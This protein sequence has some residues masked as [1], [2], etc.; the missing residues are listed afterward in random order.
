MTVN[1]IEIKKKICLIG[2][3]GVGKT[4]LIRRFV[5]DQFSDDYIATFGTKIT[6]TRIKFPKDEDNIIDLYLMIWDVFGQK[7]FKKSQMKSYT[8]AKGAIIVCDITN[9]VS[10]FNAKTWSKILFSSTGR[11]PII[12][13]ANKIDLFDYAQFSPDELNQ[14]VSEYGHS[15]FPTSAKT[16]ENVNKAFHELSRVLLEESG[17]TTKR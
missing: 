3:G 15:F 6:K 8:D 14:V 11:I 10:L 1:L 13:L 7:Q 2:D 4:S 9:R 12:F 5:L 17:I 16:G